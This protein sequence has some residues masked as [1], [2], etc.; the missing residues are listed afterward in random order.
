MWAGPPTPSERRRSEPSLGGLD[1][2]PVHLG[3]CGQGSLADAGCP[4]PPCRGPA[5]RVPTSP[6]TP[7]RSPGGGNSPVSIEPKKSCKRREPIQASTAGEAIEKM[8]E[9][10]KISSKINYSVLQDLNSKGGG[11]LRG[12][13]A[14]PQERA[15]ARKLSRRKTPAG[16]SGADPVSSVGKRYRAGRGQ[17]AWGVRSPP[18]CWE[19]TSGS[20][21]AP[22]ALAGLCLWGG[23]AAG[24]GVLPCRLCSVS[25]RG[26]P[27][28]FPGRVWSRE[29]RASPP[30]AAERPRAED[31]PGEASPA[32]PCRPHTLPL[33][34]TSQNLGQ[35]QLGGR[36]ESPGAVRF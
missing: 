11:S 1:Q 4:A 29:G 18:G 16:R 22:A 2:R 34:Q 15:G 8:L 35:Q 27:A 9:Q 10:K 3:S 31:G 33:K 30:A 17:E 19:Q 20:P 23:Q 6:E 32:A 5:S 7:S 26:E 36:L 12:G 21:A 25:G 14:Q 13:D 24:E 28:S